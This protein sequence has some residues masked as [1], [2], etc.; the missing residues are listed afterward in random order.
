[1]RNLLKYFSVNIILAL[2]LFALSVNAQVVVPNN[3]ADT[4]GDSN[5][6]FPFNCEASGN[7][8]QRYQQVYLATQFP[9]A[10]LIDMISFRLNPGTNAFGPST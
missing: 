3:L 7:P 10:G 6:A 8:S 5:N 9:Q 2:S 4:D 1:M